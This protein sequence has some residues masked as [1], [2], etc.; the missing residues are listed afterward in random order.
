MIITLL[1]SCYV[2]DKSRFIVLGVEGID[3]INDISDYC[4]GFSLT[5]S[6]VENY[7]LEANI[8]SIEKIHTEYDV[9]P[10]FVYGSGQLNGE[11]C[12]WQINAGGTG[13]INCDSHSLLTGCKHCL[14]NKI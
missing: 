8:I 13:H 12:E 3:T 9:L 11:V 7:F 14:S 5:K 2:S 6:Q 4:K 1:I 10:C